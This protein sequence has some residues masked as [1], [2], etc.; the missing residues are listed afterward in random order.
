[1]PTCSP[2]QPALVLAQLAPLQPTHLSFSSAVAS[3]AYVFVCLVVMIKPP[4]AKYS[5]VSGQVY[6]IFDTSK[7]ALLCCCVL[8][9]VSQADAV[10]SDV[11]RDA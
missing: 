2:S 5:V 1:M 10:T 9:E 4:P 6:I 8:K 7:A 3:I 11:C